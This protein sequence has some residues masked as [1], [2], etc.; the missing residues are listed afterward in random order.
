MF[1]YAIATSGQLLKRHN[2]LDITV[3]L[4]HIC[5]IR[6]TDEFDRILPNTDKHG[7]QQKGQFLFLLTV[8]NSFSLS[9]VFAPNVYVF[10]CH[11]KVV[12]ILSVSSLNLFAICPR[13]KNLRVRAV[14]NLNIFFSCKI[15]SS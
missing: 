2:H 6:Q 4:V 15:I 3:H 8:N 14:K 7:I 10:P 1:R 12:S 11:I 5:D 13:K 9:E